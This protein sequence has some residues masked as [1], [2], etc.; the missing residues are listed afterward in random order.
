MDIIKVFQRFPDHES[1]IEHLEKVRWADD[2]ECPFCQSK[3][4]ARK[5]DSERVGRWNCHACHNSYNVMHG[6][7][8]QGTKVPLQKWFL[9]ISIVLNAKKSLSS[10]QLARDLDLVQSTAWRLAMKIRNG[11]VA[12]SALLTGI[13][14]ADETYIGGKPRKGNNTRPIGKNPRG[15]GTKKLPVLG[16]AER[17]GK[18]AAQ[19]SPRVTARTLKAFLM[20]RVSSD[21]LLMTDQL[22]AYGRMGDWIRHATVDHGKCY[23]EGITHVNTIEGFWALLKRALFG[24]HHHYT[25]R[26]AAA[27][28]AE[29]CYKYNIRRNENAFGDFI[30]ATV[31]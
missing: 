9:A 7:I 3:Q 18:V 20:R 29:A 24:S 5:A 8:F 6:T 23:V 13:V 19:P 22:P 10:C 14:E 2:P 27:Y 16:V 21:A 28:V 4:V 1:C 15:R 26:H 11:M 17:N 30:Q 25:V 31:A 12:D